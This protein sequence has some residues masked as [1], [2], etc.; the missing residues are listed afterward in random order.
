MAANA[1]S[2]ST[3]GHPSDV[4]PLNAASNDRVAPSRTG[5]RIGSRSNGSNVSRTRSPAASTPYKLPAAATPVVATRQVTISNGQLLNVVPYMSTTPTPSTSSRA[6]SSSAMAPALPMK[7]A[8]G[9][10]PD[11]RNASRLPS[12]ASTANARCNASSP[13]NS[14]ATQYRPAVA[15]VR[16]PRSGSRANANR[17]NTSK[18]KGAIWFVV[19]RLRH[20]RRRSLPATSTASWNTGGHLLTSVSLDRAAG[21]PDDGRRQRRGAV[22]LMGGDHDRRSRRGRGAHQV[23]DDVTRGG[24]EPGVGLVE[25]PQL[26]PAGDHRRDR[27]SA[28]LPRRELVDRDAGQPSVDAE[29]DHRRVGLGVSGTTGARPEVDV[30]GHGEIVVETGGVPEQAHATAYGDT[31]GAVAEID[32]E[33]HRLAGDHR[34]QT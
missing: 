33:G 29:G 5:A 10:S 31:A 27:G 19:T 8:A 30:V 4:T 3:Q 18:A 34:N 24:V 21:Q 16:I 22:E 15:R 25:Q 28:S 23:V 26:G 1:A 9:F 13:L 20:S 17:I 7:I 14:T 6:H 2:S 32:T 11:M 12:D